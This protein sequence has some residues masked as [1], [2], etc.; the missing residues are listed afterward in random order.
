MIVGFDALKT[1]LKGSPQ[2]LIVVAAMEKAVLTAVEAATKAGWVKPVLLAQEDLELENSFP[3]LN[4]NAELLMTANI[5][6]AAEMGAELI[7][8]GEADIIMKGRL[9]T[10]DFLRPLLAKERGLIEPEKILSHVAV[11]ALP[12]RNRLTLIS[13][14]AISIQPDLEAKIKIIDN[15]VQLARILGY[16]PPKVAVLSALE[17]VNPKIPSSIDADQLEKMSQTNRWGD[18]LV[19][20]PL[21]LDN[22]LSMESADTKGINDEVAGQADILIVPDLVSGNFLY[23]SFSIVSLYPAAGVVVGAKMPI[24]LT[25]RADLPE[26]KVNSIALACYMKRMI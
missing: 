14:P 13:D 15:A 24:I 19:S 2:R 20:G 18:T 7:R 9:Q 4:Q 10:A 5:Q 22:A 16:H 25:S 26:T 12:G 3:Y 17:V 6:E 8:E 1:T 11:V 23:K 21:A